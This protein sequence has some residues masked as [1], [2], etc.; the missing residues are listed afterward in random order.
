M[1]ILS[2]SL[3]LSL[4]I[5]VCILFLRRLVTFPLVSAV[6]ISQPGSQIDEESLQSRPR[7]M[8]RLTRRFCHITARLFVY[9]GRDLYFRFF[10]KKYNSITLKAP[11]QLQQRLARNKY[12]YNAVIYCLKHRDKPAPLDTIDY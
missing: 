12:G 6:V 8:S 2:F 10:L 4:L 3:S 5:S 7:I 9:P 11:C 1:C